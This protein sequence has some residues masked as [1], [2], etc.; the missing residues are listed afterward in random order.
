MSL[1][2]LVSRYLVFLDF[3]SFVVVYNV[4][5]LILLNPYCLF[6]SPYLPLSLYSS[7]SIAPHFAALLCVGR[8]KIYELA[9]EVLRYKW[10]SR[11]E[12]REK[13]RGRESAARLK[14]EDEGKRERR[15]HPA[16]A[17]I[18]GV[19]E[20]DLESEVDREREG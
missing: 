18:S 3:P 19:T 9:R 1:F 17:G 12:K 4:S 6:F 2:Q 13:K 14:S 16:K 10:Q 11:G 15:G 8:P 20:I 5:Y 7:C